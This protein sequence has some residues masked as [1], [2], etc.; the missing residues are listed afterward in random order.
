MEAWLI[1]SIYSMTLVVKHI[2][3]EQLDRTTNAL[4]RYHTG[5]KFHTRAEQ[6]LAGSS[7]HIIP[8]QPDSFGMDSAQRRLAQQ[9]AGKEWMFST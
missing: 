5:G 4:S 7:I 6:L 1:S 3:G 8:L 2:T 9:P